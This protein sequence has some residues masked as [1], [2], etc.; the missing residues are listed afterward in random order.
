MDL[1]EYWLDKK[2]E[3]TWVKR[4]LT[5]STYMNKPKA[6]HERPI[7]TELA[8]L[9]DAVIKCCYAD[10]FLDECPKLSA[11]I[12]PL[13]RDEWFVTVIAKHYKILR[14]GLIEYNVLSP[15]AVECFSNY[16]FREPKE[17]R[18]GNKKDSPDKPKATVIEAMIGAIYRET[19]NLEAI[20]ELLKTWISLGNTE[21]NNYGNERNEKNI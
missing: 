6:S 5:D 14:E 11:T 4:A 3:S 21:G 2:E 17:T 7:N 20:K 15:E 8:T 1:F 9:G 13:I 12:D 19:H 18:G 10:L 16:N